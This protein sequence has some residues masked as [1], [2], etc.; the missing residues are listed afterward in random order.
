MKLQKSPSFRKVAIPWYD[1]APF[2]LTIST[3]AAFVFY[4]SLAGIGIVLENP[5]Y[6]RHCWVPATL[7]LLS[8]IVL[9]TNL[10][11]LLSR[12]VNRPEEEP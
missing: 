11:R 12:I 3:F 8:G 10:F 5:A 9:V 4:F 6:S 1:S 2:C 7:V